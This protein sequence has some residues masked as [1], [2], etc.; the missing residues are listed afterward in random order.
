MP[1]R[2]LMPLLVLLLAAAPPPLPPQLLNDPTTTEGWIWQRVQAGEVSDLNDR[3]G[4]PPLDI[5]KRD[6]DRWRASCR[7][8]NPT[9]L[10]ALL[11]QPDLADHTPHGVRII[12]ARIDGDLDLE[13]AVVR[14][15]EVVLEGSRINAVDLNDARLDGALSLQG[16]LIDGRLTG[17]RAFIGMVNMDAAVFGGSVDLELLHVGA[18]GLSLNTAKFGGPLDLRGRM[19]RAS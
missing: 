17:E 3:C 6:D 1:T 5:H 2:L 16:T 18:G 10:R 12:G 11:T 13:D 4:T 14:T 19:S 15:A 9:L 8:I 7:R